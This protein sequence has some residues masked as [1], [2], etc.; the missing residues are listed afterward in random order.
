M[1]KFSA[2]ISKMSVTC[3]S[4]ILSFIKKRTSESGIMFLI[5]ACVLVS[6]IST[7]F[8]KEVLSHHS[9]CGGYKPHLPTVNLSNV[10]A[11]YQTPTDCSCKI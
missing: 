2:W 11:F 1:H 5:S 9:L 4:A 3:A 7:D 6:I 8:L 10:G